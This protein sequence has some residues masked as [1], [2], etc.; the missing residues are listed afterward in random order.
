[1]KVKDLLETIDFNTVQWVNIID[2]DDEQLVAY[3]NNCSTRCFNCD[4]IEV[5]SMNVVT[6][7]ITNNGYRELDVYVEK[8]NN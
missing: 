1:M 8:E 3:G 7:K 2:N 5:L 6:I 4:K